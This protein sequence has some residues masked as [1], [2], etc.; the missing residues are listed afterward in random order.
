MV[1][2]LEGTKD[3]SCILE[4]LTALS[5]DVVTDD[6]KIA[7]IY[8]KSSNSNDLRGDVKSAKSA[9]KFTGTIKA[10]YGTSTASL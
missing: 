2:R 10:I 1:V 9:C 6:K 3:I 7:F 5:Y 4:K 8:R